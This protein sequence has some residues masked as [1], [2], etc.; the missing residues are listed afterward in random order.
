MIKHYEYVLKAWKPF[1]MTA[2]KD[3]HDLY[4]NGDVLLSACVFETFR[5]YWQILL[6][7]IVFIGYL[8]LAIVVVQC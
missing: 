6:N 4:L 5:K 8:L 7:E 3:Y 1:R 2:I